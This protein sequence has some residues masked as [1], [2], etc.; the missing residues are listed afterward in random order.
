MTHLGY[1]IAAYG[2]TALV[3]AGLVAWAVLDARM[4]TSRLAKLESA[5]VGR[6]SQARG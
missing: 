2:A 1:I 3:L 5:G 6:R 4:Q